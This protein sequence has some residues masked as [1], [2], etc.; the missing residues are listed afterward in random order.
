LIASLV[1]AALVTITGHR[2]KIWMIVPLVPLIQINA[3]EAVL[4]ILGVPMLASPALSLLIVLVWWEIPASKDRWQSIYRVSGLNF[5]AAMLAFSVLIPFA[6]PQSMLVTWGM[7]AGCAAI[8]GLRHRLGY[9]APLTILLLVGA[10]L[11]GLSANLWPFLLLVLGLVAIFAAEGKLPFT[12]DKATHLWLEISLALGL[13]LLGLAALI[14]KFEAVN[15]LNLVPFAPAWIYTVA[16][17]VLIWFGVRREKGIAVHAGIWLLVPAWIDLYFSISPTA[18]SYGLWLSLFAACVLLVQRLVSTQRKDKQKS[19]RTMVETMLRWPGADLALG[20]S[21]I[22]LCWTAANIT[23]YTPWILTLTFSI[24]IGVWLLT[25]LI[26]RIP[27][28][29]HL[30]LWISPMPLAMLLMHV[31]PLFYTLPMIGMAWQFY[32]IVLL[33]IGHST[34]R[35]RP[36]MRLP[37]FLT[38]YALLIFGFTTAINNALLLP[39]SLTILIIV[40]LATSLA[41]IFGYH[42]MWTLAV[43]RLV[44]PEIHPYAYRHIKHAFL[45]LSAWLAVIWLQIVLN[46]TQLT[47]S[48]QGFVLVIF[49]GLWFLLGMVIGRF[50]GLVGLPFLSAGWLLWLIGLS[51][52]FFSPTEAMLTVILGLVASIE[53]LRR[54]R[55]L[56]WL[57]LLLLQILFTVLQGAWLLHLSAPDMLCVTAFGFGIFG[58]LYKSRAP[59]SGQLTAAIGA[60]LLAGL[61]RFY[62]ALNVPLALFALSVLAT[63]IY[64]QS[65]WFWLI[66]A[67]GVLLLYQF[68]WSV[69][70]LQL[71]G[72]S[73]IQLCVGAQAALEIRPKQ[74]QR[75]N[76][77]IFTPHDWATP[78]LAVGGLG[79][80]AAL[81]MLPTQVSGLTYLLICLILAGIVTYYSVRLRL[82]YLPYVAFILAGIGI[83]VLLNAPANVPNSVSVAYNVQ[84]QVGTTAPLT[85]LMLISATLLL[86]TLCLGI[87]SRDLPVPRG[88]KAFMVVWLRPLLLLSTALGLGSLTFW[89][90]YLARWPATSPLLVIGGIGLILFLWSIYGKQSGQLLWLCTAL[91]IGGITWVVVLNLF[92]IQGIHWLFIPFGLVLLVIVREARHPRAYLLEYSGTV[93]WTIGAMVSIDRGNMF[94]V[95]SIGFF[96]YALLLL[97]YGMLVAHKVPLLN[98]AVIGGIGLVA[99]LGRVNIWFIP[100]ACGAL[101]IGGTLLLETRGEL[102]RGWMDGMQKFWHRLE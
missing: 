77:F 60:G 73:V 24:V 30:A 29:L 46:Y 22:A 42:P 5:G 16:G 85:M 68:R 51:Q 37:F 32:G 10:I 88:A 89:L 78:L 13:V 45:F 28:L 38:G 97:S 58:L 44:P 81:V 12:E 3:L 20:L 53:A 9:F 26:Y 94:S 47:W 41:V 62:P 86:R 82:I 23:L 15:N 40:S 84:S 50:P 6:T 11:L 48:Q 83:F 7:A 76:H 33:A 90:Y 67:S 65:G 57:P 21:T 43:A 99:C 39:A 87:V 36:V 59:R 35:Y 54:T 96:F 14:A 49:S 25:G 17:A 56:M 91:A 75:L 19:P 93:L 4:T 71:L 92:K 63:I 74:Y 69:N 95:N 101:L 1:A 100:M 102:V 70:P 66:Q 34:P 55:A 31:S 52:V 72:I 2:I 61:W 27:I 98:G 80:L 79:S 64:R 8:L 18:E